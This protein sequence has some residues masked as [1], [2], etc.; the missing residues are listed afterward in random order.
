M[1]NSLIFNF[2]FFTDH[3]IQRYNY[4]Q[5]TES[6]ILPYYSRRFKISSV[7]LTQNL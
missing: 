1:T 3:S 2:I 7:N 6:L 5:F 4:V